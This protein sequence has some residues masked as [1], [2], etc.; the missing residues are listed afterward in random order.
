MD[1]RRTQ[2]AQARYAPPQHPP[3]GAR[4]PAHMGGVSYEPTLLNANPHLHPGV[5]RERTGSTSSADYYASPPL[6]ADGHSQLLQY[7]RTSPAP[8]AFPEANLGRSL[9]AGAYAP[10]RQDTI[11]PG[12]PQREFSEES[13]DRNAF[14]DESF[15][16]NAYTASVA[17]FSPDRSPSIRDEALQQL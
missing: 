4:L 7:G 10:R 16:R 9:S 15:D 2:S 3:P 12:R 8:F 17:S 13:F 11:V 5:Y 1:H 14:S 6:S